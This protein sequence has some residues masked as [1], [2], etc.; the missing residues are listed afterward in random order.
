MGCITALLESGAKYV[1]KVQCAAVEGG[2]V[3]KGYEYL[4]V[5]TPMGHRCGYVAINDNHALYKEESYDSK[6]ISELKMHWGCTFY[7]KQFTDSACNDKWIGFDC[8]HSGDRPD[9]QA[10]KESFPGLHEKRLEGLKIQDEMYLH[11]CFVDHTIKTKEYVEEQ[12][13][14]IIDQL[15]TMV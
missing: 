10:T 1:N 15:T 12:C 5:L 4:I 2:G 8:A 11:P 6:K 9:T 14:S 7:G 3:H 13:K